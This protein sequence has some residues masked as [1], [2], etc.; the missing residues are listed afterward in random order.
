MIDRRLE[1]NVK[2][3]KYQIEFPNVGKFQNIETM[4]QVLSKGMYGAL[5]NTGTVTASEALDMVDIEAHLSVLIENNKLFKDLKCD[6]FAEMGLE[7]YLELKEIYRE[8]FVPWWSNIL[9]LLNPK[10]KQE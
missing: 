10:K 2:G 7:D 4:K 1:L 5:I 6:S 8:K 9:E 3:N